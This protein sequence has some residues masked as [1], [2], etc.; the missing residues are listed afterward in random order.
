[1]L[2]QTH[3]DFT[4]LHPIAEFEAYE[5]N[6]F[7]SA[8]TEQERGEIGNEVYAVE[9]KVESMAQYGFIIAGG[10]VCT[11]SDSTHLGVNLGDKIKVKGRFV[12]F[13]NLFS[14]VRLDHVVAM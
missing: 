7:V 3:Q 2:T 9:G 1:M 12:S 4:N 8:L 14:E 10:I 6:D 11:T 13:D 5:F